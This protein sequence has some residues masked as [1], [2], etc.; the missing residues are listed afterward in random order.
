MKSFLILMVLVLLISCKNQSSQQIVSLNKDSIKAIIMGIQDKMIAIIK[1]QSADRSAKFASFCDDSLLCSENSTFMPSAYAL[2][3]DLI[4]GLI[5]PPHDY[6]FRLISNTAL[7][8]YIETTFEVIGYDT[9]FQNR[10]VTKVFVLKN[11]EWKMGGLFINASQNDNYTPGVPEKNKQLYNDYI[12]IYQWKSNM[13]D[14]FFVKDGKLYDA[15]TDSPPTLTF[16]VSDSEYMSKSDFGKV[17]FGRDA[18]GK[19]SHY[20]YV[21]TNGQRMRVPKVK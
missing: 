6:T 15:M 3:Q 14:T 1:S 13:A 4:N 2:S 9:A 5:V 7:L 20:T 10:R 8:S 17:I 12:G 19:V 21:L 18:N 16:P 11:D